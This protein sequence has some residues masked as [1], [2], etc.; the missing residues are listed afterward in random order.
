[1][2]YLTNYIR[3]VS[4]TLQFAICMLLSLLMGLIDFITGDYGVTIVY[5]LPIYVSAK[6]LGERIC[7][8]FTI[9]CVMEMSA[10]A[11]FTRP[12]YANFFD[13][14]SWNAILQ[15]LL[16]GI[17]GFLISRITNQLGNTSP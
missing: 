17:T 11:W 2:I 16:L 15:L 7:I 1:M 5:L 14:Y 9:L 12:F 4:R 10:V 8:G 6:L 13:A 3:N